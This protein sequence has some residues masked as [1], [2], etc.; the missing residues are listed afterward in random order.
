[1][2]GWLVVGG[3]RGGQRG[4]QEGSSVVAGA[5]LEGGSLP[6][7]VVADSP[8]IGEIL[9]REEVRKRK[10]FDLDYYGSGG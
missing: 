2:G 7:R 10:R 8:A 5:T 4:C 9:S 6:E 3:E 1:M